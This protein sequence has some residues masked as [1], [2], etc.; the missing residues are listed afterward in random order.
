VIFPAAPIFFNPICKQKIWGGNALRTRFKRAIEGN[1]FIG[2]SWEIVSHRDDQSIV[3][4]GALAGTA[5][6]RLVAEHPREL[7]G[8]I[9][10]F[11]KFPLLYK[12][13][14]ARHRLSVQVHPNDRQARAGQWGEFGKTECWYIV[15]APENASII[16][17][18]AH[19]VTAEQVRKAIET[20]TV[21]ELLNSHPVKSG[22]L[23]YVPAGTVHAILEGTIIY[24]IQETSDTTLRLYDWGRL[25]EKQRP[26]MLH[27]KDALSIID[28]AANR[29]YSIPPV[30]LECAGAVHMLRIACRYF[31]VEQ[32]DYQRDD[33]II[34]QA[35]QSFRVITVLD[36]PV[37]LQYPSGTAVVSPGC[38]VLLP[39][40]LRDVRAFGTAGTR[41]LVSWVPDLQSEII[42]PL[43]NRGV[44]A[45]SIERL[46]G[47]PKHNDL[48]K[49]LRKQK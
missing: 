48:S 32:F 47:I 28:T 18:F 2:E 31:A 42:A 24:E 13:I 45:D 17:G 3:T 33:E 25:D 36:G 38:T 6:D 20:G 46:G 1:D 22:D 27:V 43:L 26:R 15:D 10:T 9:Q 5:I 30:M 35:R 21:S 7:L 41:I 8:N 19:D 37:R 12:F 23:I 29:D 39:A 49:Y 4:E 40:I 11:G 44:S 16:T 34:L 14:D